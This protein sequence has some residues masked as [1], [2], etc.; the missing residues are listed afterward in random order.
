MNG[1]TRSLECYS[2]SCQGQ[3]P[4][5]DKVLAKERQDRSDENHGTTHG[6]SAVR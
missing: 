5:P 2:R 1:E 3:I 4:L 6:G